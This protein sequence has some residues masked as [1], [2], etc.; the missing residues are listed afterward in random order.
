MKYLGHV[1]IERTEDIYED[2]ETGNIYKIVSEKT[3]DSGI[4]T[5][6]DSE[7]YIEIYQDSMMHPN[8]LYV[9][10]DPG[11]VELLLKKILSSEK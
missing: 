4:E 6:P 2:T 5:A 9:E 1:E 3:Y 8:N 10:K 7:L 11:Q